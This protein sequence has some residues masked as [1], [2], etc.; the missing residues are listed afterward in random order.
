MRAYAGP[1]FY[2]LECERVRDGKTE[3]TG[4]SYGRDRSFAVA[5]ACSIYL[6]LGYTVTLKTVDDRYPANVLSREP[7]LPQ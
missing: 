2:H 5:D 7:I 3:T 1:R 6:P 4:A